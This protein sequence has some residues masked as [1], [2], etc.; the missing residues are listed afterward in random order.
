MLV[1]DQTLC[2]YNS[3][4]IVGL[5]LKIAPMNSEGYYIGLEKG[6]RVKMRKFMIFMNYLLRSPEAKGTPAKL[7]S[8]V[9]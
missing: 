9:D 7:Y 3:V 6:A 4:V 2:S 8:K 1:L 5:T